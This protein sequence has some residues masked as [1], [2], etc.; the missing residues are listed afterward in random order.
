MQHVITIRKPVKRDDFL[1][2]RCD[3]GGQ[4]TCVSFEDKEEG[5]IFA[6][7]ALEDKESGPVRLTLKGTRELRIAHYPDQV[8]TFIEQGAYVVP[9]TNNTIVEGESY[10]AIG[11]VRK[12]A[13]YASTVEVDYCSHLIKDLADVSSFV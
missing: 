9:A 8:D 13:L 2:A 5:D 1:Y 6:G 3:K 4:F 7:I 12:D 10:K 11:Q